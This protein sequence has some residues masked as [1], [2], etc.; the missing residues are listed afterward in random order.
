MAKFRE[1]IEARRLRFDGESIKNIA[2]KLDVSKSSASLWCRD[3]KLSEAQIKELAKKENSGA[4]KGRL[5]A[6]ENRR[7]ERLQRVEI[8][9]NIGKNKI[10]RLTEREIFLLGVA[11]YWA[12]GSKK[13]RR[14]T[15]I[16]SDPKII[17]LWIHWLR[18]FGGLKTR[19]LKCTVGINE[20]HEKRLS[21]VI[22]YW[23]KITRISKKQFAKSSLKRVRNKKIYANYWQ[24][25]GSLTIEARKGANLNYE[26]LGMI[27]GIRSHF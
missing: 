4:Y 12:E 11:L 15:L 19:D 24:H 14:V 22:R 25:Y 21:S 13:D 5:I 17:Q 1:R 27:E 3:I 7:K 23:S 2:K 6:A 9:G 26:I 16:N 18:K 20:M 8:F 10:G